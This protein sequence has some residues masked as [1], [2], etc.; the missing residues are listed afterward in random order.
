M[1]II[2]DSPWFVPARIGI[3]LPLQVDDENVYPL[4]F[5][6]DT[7]APR[8]FHLGRR[9]VE[10]QGDEGVMSEVGENEVHDFELTIDRVVAEA[11]PVHYEP[12]PEDIRAN[13]MGL[14]AILWAFNILHTTQMDEALTIPLGGTPAPAPDTPLVREVDE[15]CAMQTLYLLILSL[16]NQVTLNGYIQH[17]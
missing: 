12:K 4:P 16:G 17:Y 2:P 9:C 7:G 10:V 3:I 6:I 13:V 14:V 15:F 11:L 1:F 8:F 5:I